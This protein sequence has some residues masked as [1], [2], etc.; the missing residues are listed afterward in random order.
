MNRYAITVRRWW[1]IPAALALLVL[2]CWAVGT[3]TVPVP[4]L[5]RGAGG[6]QLAYFT[7]LL[8]VIAVMYCLERQLHE[9]ETTAALPV[10]RFDQ[11]AVILTA[12]FAHAAGL[13]VG[14]DIARNVTILLGIALLARRLAN[15][16]TAAGAGLMFLIINI[17]LGRV[18]GPNGH[19]THAWW[20]IVLYP[21][22]NMPA[23]LVAV[24]L[25][26]LALPLSFSRTLASR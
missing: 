18:I 6:A 8:V 22:G 14:M 13:M 11:G 20:A 21:S 9:A 10:R 2:V 24:A 15:E 4:S 3:S 12:V 1:T 25:F 19:S 17:V 5:T 23:W 7:P 26:A 16:A